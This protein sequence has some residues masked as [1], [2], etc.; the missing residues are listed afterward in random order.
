MIQRWR[1]KTSVI[2][3]NMLLECVFLFQVLSSLAEM[4]SGPF[5]RR[6]WVTQSLRVTAKEMSLVS[7][8]GKNNAIAERFSK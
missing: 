6:S 1:G 5:N 8:R 3:H 2:K 4:E 7:G